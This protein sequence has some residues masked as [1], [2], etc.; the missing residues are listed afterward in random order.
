[1]KLFRT[2]NKNGLKQILE[3]ISRE[4]GTPKPVNVEALCVACDHVIHNLA[5][6]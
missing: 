4:V 6:V 5:R 2:I 3:S 1:M